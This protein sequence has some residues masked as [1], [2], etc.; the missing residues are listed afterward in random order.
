M[1]SSMGVS[2]AV[3]GRKSIRAFTNDPVPEELVKKLLTLAARAPSGGNTQPWHVY[4]VTGDAR[5]SLTDAVFEAMSNGKMGDKPEFNIYPKSSDAPEYLERRRKLGYEMYKLM[6]IDRDDKAGRLAAMQQNFEF[7]GAPVGLIV[8]VDRVA[9]RN[10][11]GHVGMFLQ[12]LCLLAT[13]HGLAS[14]L[15]E[16]WSTFHSVVY[17]K[18]QIPA[19]QIVWCGVA[20]GYEDKGAPV[21]KLVSEREPPEK[22]AKFH[23]GKL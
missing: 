14:C 8:T 17:E 3:E 12:T 23:T 22:F 6:D 4:V 7:F 13:E 5:Q 2:K 16:A 19:S 18:L 11:W 20:L 1:A 10:G 21:N 15:Q 9:D